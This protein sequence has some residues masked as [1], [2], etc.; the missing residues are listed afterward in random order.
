M[1]IFHIFLII[2]LCRRDIVLKRVFSKVNIMKQRCLLIFII[3]IWISTPVFLH[4]ATSTVNTTD[5]TNDTSPGDGEAVDAAGEDGVPEIAIGRLPVSSVGELHSMIRKIISYESSRGSGRVLMAADDADK[6][7]NFP[8]DSNR[9]MHLIPKNY[10]VSRVYLSMLN[11]Q[12]A[13]QKII[14]GINNGADI[15]N[16]I[17]HAGMFSLAHEDILDKTDVRLMNNSGKYP[18]A[19]FLTCAVGNF[20][21]PGYDCLAEY[22]VMQKS[23]GAAA[24]WSPSGASVNSYASSLGTGFYKTAFS[25]LQNIR[26]GDAV[27]AGLSNAAGAPAYIFQLYNIIGDPAMVLK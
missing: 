3:V 16:F 12:N 24:V 10:G 4:P 20:A 1:F 26:L 7:G 22:L 6:G 9:M 5:D 2:S 17:G 25:G 11:P 14:Q 8:E 19:V 21:I 13:R 23:S 18:V 15:F 27:L